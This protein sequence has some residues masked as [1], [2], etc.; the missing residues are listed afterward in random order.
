MNPEL[1]GYALTADG[2][3]IHAK[4]TLRF[5]IE[6]P[7]H[8]VFDFAGT[9]NQAFGLSGISNAVISVLDNAL[10]YAASRSRVDEVP[11]G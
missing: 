3:I 2:N 4:A 10:L 7:V 11:A 1:D 8:C 6:D 9:G 5:R